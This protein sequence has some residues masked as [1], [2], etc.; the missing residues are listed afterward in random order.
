MKYLPLLGKALK[1]AEIIDLFETNDIDVVYD[2]DRCYENMP[3]QY[4]ATSHDLGIQI[5][6]DE[7]QILKTIFIYMTSEDEFTPA[8]ILNSDITIFDSKPAVRNHAL[9]NNIN[10]TEGHTT[11]LGTES[12]WIRFDY[13]DHRIHYEFSGGQLKKVRLTLN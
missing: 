12:D 1:N 11:F 3:D 9:E 6:F 7:D 13:P 4:W 8:D 2:F 10:I 5:N